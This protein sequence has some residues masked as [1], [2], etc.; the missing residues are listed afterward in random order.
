MWLPDEKELQNNVAAKALINSIVST[1][2]SDPGAL[3]TVVFPL[4]SI[5]DL[6]KLCHENFAGYSKS[7][8]GV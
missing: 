6:I 5:S 1:I 4:P 7:E 8:Q 3:L 2:S